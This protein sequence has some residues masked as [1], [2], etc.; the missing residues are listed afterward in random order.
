MI[1]GNK[2][3]GL[4][5][6]IDIK[7]LLNWRNEMIFDR[8]LTSSLS[9]AL[10]RKYQTFN[11]EQWILDLVEKDSEFIVFYSPNNFYDISETGRKQVEKFTRE[12]LNKHN[13]NNIKFIFWR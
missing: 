11:T 8:D 6:E 1:S 12:W 2:T 9:W 3:E 5:S 13:Y 4:L 7:L 10:V